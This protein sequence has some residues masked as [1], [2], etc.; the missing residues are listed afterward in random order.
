MTLEKELNIIKAIE[1]IAILANINTDG[2]IKQKHHA[3]LRALKSTLN[4]YKN[5]DTIEFEHSLIPDDKVQIMWENL[6]I[7]SFDIEN[8]FINFTCISS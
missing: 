2:I 4:Y 6:H 1:D 7:Y 8:F 3:V 5:K